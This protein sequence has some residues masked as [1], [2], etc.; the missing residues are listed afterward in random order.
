M[1]SDR[2]QTDFLTYNPLIYMPL[3]PFYYYLKCQY[4]KAKIKQYSFMLTINQL[5]ILEKNWQS[6]WLNR[7]KNN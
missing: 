3:S 7:I 5:K 1:V 2:Y 4:D 6:F